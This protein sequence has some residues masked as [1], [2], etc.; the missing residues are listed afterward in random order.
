MKRES[1]GTSKGGQFAPDTSGKTPPSSEPIPVVAVPSAQLGAHVTSVQRVRYAEK[2]ESLWSYTRDPQVGIPQ[3]VPYF[4]SVAASDFE[5]DM[6]KD[7][8]FTPWQVEASNK[9]DVTERDEAYKLAMKSVGLENMHMPYECLSREDRR[10]A[11]ETY[12]AKLDQLMKQHAN[13]DNRDYR[14]NPGIMVAL[15]PREHQSLKIFRDITTSLRN[16]EAE[17]A[18]EKFFNAIYYDAALTE[19]QR[20]AFDQPSTKK[21]QGVAVRAAFK[22]VGYPITGRYEDMTATQET[23]ATRNFYAALQ[24]QRARVS[25]K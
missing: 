14:G 20:K 8:D 3:W 7:W 21:E 13:A 4:V 15:A 12:F 6:E 17:K 10:I 5:T 18:G 22:A 2:K 11:A 24:Y 16:R 19:N 23:Y 1:K 9:A 25:N